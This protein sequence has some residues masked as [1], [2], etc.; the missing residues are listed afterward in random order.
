MSNV[1]IHLYDFQYKC[2]V[3]LL[4]SKHTKPDIGVE[5]IKSMTNTEERDTAAATQS[6]VKEPHV[7]E[8]NANA[9]ELKDESPAV[10]TEQVTTIGE[11]MLEYHLQGRRHKAQELKASKQVNE[12][13]GSSSLFQSKHTKPDIGVEEIQGNDYY[14]GEGNSCSNPGNYCWSS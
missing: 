8:E 9:G 4:Q 10:A 14:R 13:E 2:H 5:E 7:A 12:S 1:D 3:P 6:K 11:K